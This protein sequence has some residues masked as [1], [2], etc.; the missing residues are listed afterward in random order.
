MTDTQ[1]DR[2]RGVDGVDWAVPFYKGLTVAH[3]R[4]GMLQQVILLGV[5]DAT[6]DRC[7]A[8]HGAGLQSR[9]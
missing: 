2:V 6:P 5:D 1:L 4:D 7:H 8:A 9:T 3:A